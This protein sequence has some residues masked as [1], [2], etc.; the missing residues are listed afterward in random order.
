MK[1]RTEFARLV[2]RRHQIPWN[3]LVQALGAFLLL[4]AV[5]LRS[6]VEAWAGIGLLLA[7]VLD[8]HLPPFP[9]K[10][11]M[12]RLVR[13]MIQA[14]VV[15]INRPWDRRKW[16]AMVL[17]LLGALLVLTTLWLDSL[18]GLGLLV[19]IFV[20]LRVRAANKEAGIDP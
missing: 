1:P 16:V 9:E 13:R 3:W 15:W 10:T 11:F 12:A 6:G 17:L 5:W 14:E 8:F 18:P 2:W 20:L 4:F 19:G 7:G